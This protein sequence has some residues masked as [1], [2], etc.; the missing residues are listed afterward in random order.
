[1]GRVGSR[2]SVIVAGRV[3]LGR[4]YRLSSRVPKF[5]PECNSEL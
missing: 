3:E 4:D 1:M 2:K 5:G